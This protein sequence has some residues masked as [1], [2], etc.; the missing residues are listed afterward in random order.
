[1][2]IEKLAIQASR[3]KLVPFCLTYDKNYTVNW[4]HRVLA[5]ALEKVESGE[6]KRLIIEMPPRHGKSQ[7]ASIY[8]PAWFLGRNPDKEIITCSYSAELAKDFGGKTRDVLLDQQYQSIFPTKVKQDSKSKDKWQTEDNG[9]YTSVGIGGAITG[10]GANVLLIDDPL[11]NREEAESKVFRDKIWDWYTSTA[12]TRLEKGASVIVIMTRWHMDDLVGRL[13]EN[14]KEGGEKWHKISFPAISVEKE[15]Y[16]D[17]NEPLWKEKYDL[18]TLERMKKTVGIYDWNS[19]FQQTPVAAET[20]EFKN[21]WF[22]YY[23]QKDLIGKE[24]EV[25]VTVDLAISQRDSADYT[26]IQV[27]GKE[28]HKPEWYHLEEN[29]NRLNPGEVIDYLF[30]IENKYGYRLRKV[31]IEG[32][33][34]QKSLFYFLEEEMKRRQTYFDI[35]ELK[36]SGPKETRI[37][38]LIPMYRM[39]LIK[40]R[41]TDHDLEEELLVFPS[42]KHDD[43]IDALSYMNQLVNITTSKKVKQ[44]RPNVSMYR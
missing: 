4:H 3:D 28:K 44:F 30:Y 33:A 8:F 38:G 29:T 22:Q 2:S 9:S 16:R 31:G 18:E 26:S 41:R 27:V 17:A 39:G 11:K 15:E 5:D 19:L 34:Y 25:Y 7:L 43:R 20:Q 23:D 32:V 37:R 21:E 24:L 40:H 10:R 36:A 6:I 12:Y 13:V 42:G 14:E 35:Y 1:M